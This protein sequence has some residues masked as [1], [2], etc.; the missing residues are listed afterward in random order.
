[1]RDSRPSATEQFFYSAKKGE[2]PVSIPVVVANDKKGL[3]TQGL[4]LNENNVRELVFSDD[5]IERVVGAL[6]ACAYVS[7]TLTKRNCGIKPLHRMRY[8]R[9]NL[10]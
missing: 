6:F 10:W 1:M 7:D 3:L 2:L 5:H 9:P 4:Y 8:C